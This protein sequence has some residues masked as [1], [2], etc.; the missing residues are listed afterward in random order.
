M[1]GKILDDTKIEQIRG[2]AIEYVVS[3]SAI[4]SEKDLGASILALAAHGRAVAEKVEELKA[5]LETYANHDEEL[6]VMEQA[7]KAAARQCRNDLTPEDHK[8]IAKVDRENIRQAKETRPAWSATILDEM[9]IAYETEIEVVGVVLPD[10]PRPAKLPGT[11][12]SATGPGRFE[13]GK[14]RNHNHGGPWLVWTPNGSTRQADS[15]VIDT[16]GARLEIAGTH[17]ERMFRDGGW[18]LQF[19]IRTAPF[20]AAL[21]ESQATAVARQDAKEKGAGYIYRIGQLC[22]RLDPD[23][24]EVIWPGIEVE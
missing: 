5:C 15:H 10:A 3:E 20:E 11:P 23:K 1:A 12:F 7:L 17:L 22:Y 16:G 14:A 18:P 9:A 21:E 13:Y 6:A 2:E 4:E 8:R 19:S 24:V